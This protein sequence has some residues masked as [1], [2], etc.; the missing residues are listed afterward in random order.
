MEYTL[1]V[2]FLLL[3][4][5]FFWLLKKSY[6]MILLFKPFVA[7]M[8]KIFLYKEISHR[9]FCYHYI[10]SQRYTHLGMCMLTRQAPFEFLVLPKE[11][12]NLCTL[13]LFRH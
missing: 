10:P 4:F 13:L 1:N 9:F 7:F 2:V 11:H 8:N 5:V 3:T 12:G 6:L